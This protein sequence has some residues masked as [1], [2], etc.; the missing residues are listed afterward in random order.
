MSQNYAFDIDIPDGNSLDNSYE[1]H[2]DELTY[3]DNESFHNPYNSQ[4]KSHDGSNFRSSVS[5]FSN[6]SG[7]VEESIPFT[8][9]ETNYQWS[10]HDKKTHGHLD[11]DPEFERKGRS[12]KGGQNKQSDSRGLEDTER[13][14]QEEFSESFD[15]T[16]TSGSSRQILMFGTSNGPP[17]HIDGHMKTSQ[18]RHHPRDDADDTSRPKVFKKEGIIITPINSNSRDPLHT[19]HVQAYIAGAGEV[20]SRTTLNE[21]LPETNVRRRSEGKMESQMNSL[22]VYPNSYQQDPSQQESKFDNQK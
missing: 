4:G 16:P 7:Q 10:Q 22:K 1:M 2:R 13:V 12:M 8:G 20:S 19:T 3:W 14:D 6:I 9:N 5:I 15:R 21:L 17:M 11:K 18:Q